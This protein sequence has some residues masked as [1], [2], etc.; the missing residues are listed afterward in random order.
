[1]LA[2][3]ELVAV[4]GTC[5]NGFRLWVDGEP[6]IEAWPGGTMEDWSTTW[7]HDLRLA[8]GTH[9]IAVQANNIDFAAGGDSPAALLVALLAINE[10]TG[11]FA[12][13]IDRH[14]SSWIC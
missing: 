4:C 3:D 8:A 11:A 2:S 13:V 9:Q 12:S 14:D 5:D 7:R 6:M 10:T 1:T